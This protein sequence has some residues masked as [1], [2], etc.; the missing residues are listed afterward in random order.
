[1]DVP[2]NDNNYICLSGKASLFLTSGYAV[3]KIEYKAT[4]R[5]I[6]IKQK[7]GNLP[8]GT[9]LTTNAGQ[10]VVMNGRFSYLHVDTCGNET[11]DEVRS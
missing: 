9:V 11:Y 1:M 8:V 2:E 7:Y 4:G 6:H 3:D 10:A 5:T